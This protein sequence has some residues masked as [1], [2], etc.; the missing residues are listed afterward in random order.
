[1]QKVTPFLLFEGKAEETYG[2]TF[3]PSLSLFIE[4]DSSEELE[5]LHQ[6]L[7]NNGKVLMPIADT[8]ISEK[9]SW[10][11]DRYGVSWQLNMMKK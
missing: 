7:S 10:V 4:C 2:F 1:M 3:T 5:E 6:K 8:P 11:E 9:F